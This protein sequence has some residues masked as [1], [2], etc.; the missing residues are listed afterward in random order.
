M[1]YKYVLNI[2][3]LLALFGCRKKEGT[4]TPPP[5]VVPATMRVV[6]ASV[7]GAS[8]TDFFPRSI[9][10]QLQLMFSDRIDRGTLATSI[11]YTDATGAV[12]TF[13]ASWQ[14]S[15]S[16]LILQ[17]RT[18][19]TAGLSQYAVRLLRTLKSVSGAVLD[20]EKSYQITTGID[21]TAKFPVITDDS[22]MTLVQKQTFSY[23]WDFGHPVSGM[24]RERNSSGDVVT[25]GGT[26]FGIMSMVVASE[27][28][29]ITRQQAAERVTKIADF[30]KTKAIPYH[31]TFAHWINGISGATVPFSANDNGADLVETSF[32]MMGL[33]TARQYFDG[34]GALESGLRTQ[35][36]SLYNAVE[37][38]WFRKGSEQVLYW[39][40][41]PDKGWAIN[42]KIQGW[43]ECLITYVLAAGSPTYPVSDTVYREGFARNGNMR[44][45][46]SYNGINLPLGSNFGGPLFLAHYSFL[47][48]HPTNLKDT[49]ADYGVQNRNHTLIN[50]NYCTNNTQNYRGYS[51]ACWGLTASDIPGG[52]TAS[53]PTN[54]RGVIAPT[55]AI[56]SM[57]FAPLESMRAL[58]FFYDILG[59]KL[60]KNYGF[61]D[62]FSIHERW[63]ASSFLAIDQGPQI[64]MI[65][66]HRTGLVWNLGMKVPEVKA[67]L[68]K[69]GFT[70]PYL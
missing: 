26:G 27:R 49:Y 40:W 35:I 44:N 42:L 9:R 41:S 65:E 59:D 12:V 8:G 63:F 52:Y 51:N 60:W 34:A 10:P 61:I 50:F 62:A 47:G 25:T 38:S 19:Q 23:F 31:G 22:L 37:W 13:D 32:L 6:L 18:G 24:A 16:L 1:K 28:G 46:N 55:A 3:L 64:I 57:P 58:R 4:G 56:A 15:D 48:I 68:T 69:L 17:P 67:G 21:S 30:L 66:N 7:D 14:K 2:F 11:N 29:F 53:S 45:G 33:L 20:A 5:P 39:H 70:S 54:D 36:T 43:N